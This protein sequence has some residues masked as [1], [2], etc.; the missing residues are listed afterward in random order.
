MIRYLS[1]AEVA[2]R[3]GVQSD[4]LRHYKMPDPDAMVGKRRGWLVQTIDNWNRNR[5][6]RGRW[7][8]RAEM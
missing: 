3:I 1:R 7:G 8:S 6:G 5:P 4:S 2:A